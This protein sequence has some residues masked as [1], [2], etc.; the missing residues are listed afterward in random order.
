[1]TTEQIAQDVL[2][3]LEEAWNAGDGDAF[4]RPYRDD[5]S[6]VTIRGEWVHGGEIGAG[7][8]HIFRTIYAGSTNRMELV[9]ARRVSDDVIIATS[10][11]T[12]T[13]PHGPLAGV[14][15]AMS[16]SVLVRAGD[17]WLIATSNNTLVAER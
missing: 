1:M 13:A 12:L 7:H 5:A 14:H 2:A 15:A 6:F 3:R 11:N 8:D 16:T 10:R 9:E 17:E 4:G